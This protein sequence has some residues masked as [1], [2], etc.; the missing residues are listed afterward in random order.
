MPYHPRSISQ[1]PSQRDCFTSPLADAHGFRTHLEAEQVMG[2]FWLVA[3]A[4][5]CW[6]LSPIGSLSN[7]SIALATLCRNSAIPFPEFWAPAIA[8]KNQ[9]KEKKR[10]T[11]SDVTVLCQTNA[12]QVLQEGHTVPPSS[13]CHFVFLASQN[14][15]RAGSIRLPAW[16]VE[17]RQFGTSLLHAVSVCNG[18]Q[19]WGCLNARKPDHHGQPNHKESRISRF[20]MIPLRFRMELIHLIYLFS[21]VGRLKIA[22]N[23]NT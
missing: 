5:T 10:L 17:V 20:N 22:R 19:F 23:P 4:G 16:L 8:K 2:L 1:S 18:L 9:K 13:Q 21:Y 14:S 15:G 7:L 12:S 11:T 3:F 6:H